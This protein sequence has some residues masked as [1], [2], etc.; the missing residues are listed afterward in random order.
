MEYKFP[1]AQRKRV[2]YIFLLYSG[3]KIVGKILVNSKTNLDKVTPS[4]LIRLLYFY[5]YVATVSS[6]INLPHLEAYDRS[7]HSYAVVLFSGF[8]QQLRNTRHIR[9]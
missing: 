4:S 2:R 3:T 9:L 6:L 5:H 7:A 1:H 8:K